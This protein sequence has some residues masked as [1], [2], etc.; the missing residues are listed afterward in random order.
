[1]NSKKTR[2]HDTFNSRYREIDQIIR[3]EENGV[4]FDGSKFDE[5]FVLALKI[6]NFVNHYS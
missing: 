3:I 6:D 5:L 2:G 1:M 4:N